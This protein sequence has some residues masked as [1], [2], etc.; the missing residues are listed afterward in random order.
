[1]EY[2]P[3]FRGEQALLERVALLFGRAL[4]NLSNLLIPGKRLANHRTRDALPVGING[5]IVEVVEN[6][7]D[8]D[9]WR[10]AC[11]RT[12]DASVRYLSGG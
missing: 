1:M 4:A 2:P 3:A 6:G 8:L 10:K 9:I 5:P 11:A 12:P 7:V